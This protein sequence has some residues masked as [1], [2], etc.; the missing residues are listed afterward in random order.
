MEKELKIHNEKFEIATLEN[1]GEQ[2]IALSKIITELEA[3]ISH[4]YEELCELVDMCETEAS[5]FNERLK[6]FE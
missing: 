3:T 1:Q 2:I 5:I 6:E 4:V